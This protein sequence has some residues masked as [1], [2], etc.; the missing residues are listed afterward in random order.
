MKLASKSAIRQPGLD[1]QT[2][3]Q[4]CRLPGKQVRKKASKAASKA[5]SK[6]ATGP[7][8]TSSGRQILTGQPA[9]LIAASAGPSSSS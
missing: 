1:R 4:M 2:N 9:M 5:A 7:M 6:Q 8:H 3:M